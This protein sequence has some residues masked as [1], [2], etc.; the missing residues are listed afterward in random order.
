MSGV[1][2]RTSPAS[3]AATTRAA[4]N[5]TVDATNGDD[6]V[7]VSGVRA[8]VAGQRLAAA[9]LGVR[10]HRRQRPA[11]GQRAGRRRRDRRLRSGRP[12]PRCSRSTAARATTCC[13]AARATTRCSA[14]RATTCCS[15]APGND[16]L[17]GGPGDNVVIQSSAPTRSPR[18]PRSGGVAEAHARTVEARPCSRCDGKKHRLPHAKLRPGARFMT[19]G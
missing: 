11:D 19:V 12:P 10:R 6:V 1:V 7:I 15:A 5:V 13:S 9:G 18:R 3:A 16:I 14:A 2:T 4:D 17:D 8:N